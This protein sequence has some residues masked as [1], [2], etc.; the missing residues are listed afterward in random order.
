M[1]WAAFHQH[2]AWLLLMAAALSLILVIDPLL[3]AAQE[4]EKHRADDLAI[5]WKRWREAQSHFHNGVSNTAITMADIDRLLAPVQRLHVAAD[6]ERQ[7]STSRL[8]H[9]T[10][11]L[12]PENKAHADL[13]DSGDLA[14][15]D[16][17]MS[18]D[19]PLDS[20]VYAFLQ[21]ASRNL[22]GRVTL[23]RLSVARLTTDA[24]LTL[25][26]AHMEATLDWLSNGANADKVGKP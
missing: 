5:Q 22:P 20:D 9:F 24:P 21:N 25:A 1:N 15:S 8:S 16:V 3:N 4:H 19:A 14:E 6:L 2:R 7:A 26:N 13:L 12:G 23:K 18:A 11:T 17:V 10:Y